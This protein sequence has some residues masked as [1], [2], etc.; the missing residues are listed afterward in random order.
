[1]GPDSNTGN[2][3]AENYVSWTFRKQAKFFDIVTYTGNGASQRSISHSLGAAP[4]MVIVKSLSNAQNWYVT[5]RR[6]GSDPSMGCGMYLNTTDSRQITFVGT[7][8]GSSSTFEVG[9]Q[10][11]WASNSLGYT[12]VA[13]LFAHDAGGFGP[14]GNDNAISCGS[15]T[16]NGLADG[17]TITLGYEP[18]WVLIKAASTS[19]NWH[20]YDN[21]RG[22]TNA[23]IDAI[24]YANL[25][26]AEDATNSNLI[27]PTAT[28]FKLTANYVAN[29]SG[30]D[31][32]YMA[33]R[34]GPMRTPTSGTSV[35]TSN[36][37]TGSGTTTDYD[38]GIVADLSV[39]KR[40]STSGEYTLFFDRL[41]GERTVIANSTAQEYVSTDFGAG[42]LFPSFLTSGKQTV[43]QYRTSDTGW[44]SS[45]VTYMNWFF[46]RAPGFFDIVC[47]TG[48]GAQQNLSHNLGVVPEF[49]AVK[50]RSAASGANG[51]PTFSSSA[52]QIMWLNLTL[53]RQAFSNCFPVAPTA[54]VFTVGSNSD[55]GAN[56]VTYVAYLFASCPGVSKVGSYTGTGAAQTINCGFTGGARFVMIKRT[57]STGSW[58]VWDTTRGIIS[59]DDPYLMFNNN[60][61]EVTNTDYIDPEST[62]FQITSTATA[63]LNANGGAYFFL[64]IA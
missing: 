1:M 30:I 42:R 47:Y 16:G 52:D 26:N 34:R 63:E 2:N 38:T 7:D 9:N 4:G 12:Y 15:Y 60:T 53:S 39:V 6:G 10:S 54:S 31:Y 50:S 45:G 55:A 25:S 29:Q 3:N 37:Y 21:M 20:L 64:A 57:N 44:N 24:L 46:K 49:I 14:T 28:G 19:G 51:W 22:W 33:I 62:G 43:Y 23:S 17:P 13:Y 48:T 35:F 41:R 58:Y 61:A 18:Q 32:I 59:A 40:R 36:A 5:H 8:I 56:A 27:A 11:G